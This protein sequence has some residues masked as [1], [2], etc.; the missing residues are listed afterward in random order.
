MPSVYV[1]KKTKEK[2]QKF[3]ERSRISPEFGAKKKYPSPSKA[4]EFLL[5]IGLK[6]PFNY[7][8]NLAK[9][10]HVQSSMS[11]EDW[12]NEEI[13][14]KKIL[15]NLTMF[16]QETEDRKPHCRKCG[17]E[18]DPINKMC[19][20][21]GKTLCRICVICEKLFRLEYED[22]LF[23]QVCYK[24]ECVKKFRYHCGTGDRYWRT[25]KQKKDQ[26]YKKNRRKVK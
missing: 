5:K 1:S 16:R 2:L 18:R 4:I 14:D 15:R 20:D 3:I 23:R 24:K 12:D 7:L 8:E 9:L 19:P 25:E 17:S 11:P 6:Y 21:C 22:T 10:P 26:I 13:R